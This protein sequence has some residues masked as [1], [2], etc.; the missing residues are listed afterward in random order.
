MRVRSLACLAFL[1]LTTAAFC[2]ALASEPPGVLVN[3]FIYDKAPFPS[4]H[5]STIENTPA[6][7]VAA[8]FGGSD[9]GNDDVGIW[10]CRHDGKTWGPPVEAANGIESESKRYPC[11][12]P[13]L[14]Q[15]PDGPLLLFYKVGPSPIRWW[16]M[17]ISSTDNGQTWS[18]PMRLPEGILGPI[19]N[20][21]V[22]VKGQLICPSS[23]EHDGGRWQV[24][25][26]STPDWGKTWTKTPPLGDGV[27]FGVIQP[28]LVTYPD[29]KLQILC[30]SKQR[31]VVDSWSSD[32]GKTWSPL[33][34]TVLPNPNSGIDAANL[35]DG[36][37]LLVYNHTQRGRSPI[38]VALSTDGKSWAA[39]I[40]LETEKGEFSYPAVICTPDGHAH[41]T[42]TWKRQKLK[43]IEIDPA[44]L[45]RQAMPNG[46]WPQ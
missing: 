32:N 7:L 20:K 25:M 21:P 15:A 26:E 8:F 24:H 27:E 41:I 36:S 4:C 1:S 40:P 3:Q 17:L 13:V 9:E 42:Y 23:T 37:V 34:T 22:L 16:G 39:G 11:W 30:R 44:K 29:G 18:N 38:N 2:E 43:H 33:A 19:K 14:F 5:A 6:G 46:E 28:T 31:Q 10:V 35:K 45:P 12:N